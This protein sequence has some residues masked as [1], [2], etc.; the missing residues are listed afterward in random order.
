MHNDADDS[1]I[2]EGVGGENQYA[3]I[4]AVTYY[5]QTESIKCCQVS[6]LMAA[7]F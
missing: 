4:V 2:V 6:G 7:Y 3:A 1:A 5:F